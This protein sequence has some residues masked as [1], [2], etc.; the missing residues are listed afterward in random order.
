MKVNGP[1][2][3]TLRKNIGIDYIIYGNTI[4]HT[5]VHD[6]VGIQND[7]SAL[8]IGNGIRR[9]IYVGIAGNNALLSLFLC[10]FFGCSEKIADRYITIGSIRII[11]NTTTGRIGVRN[12]ND[13][14]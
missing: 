5:Q 4:D 14:G 2:G 9:G 13:L 12:S 1:D 10:P 6:N 7:G 3:I 11:W 8:N